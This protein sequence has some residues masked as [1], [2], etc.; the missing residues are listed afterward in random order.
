MLLWIIAIAAA[1]IAIAVALH[2][3]A[4]AREFLRDHRSRSLWSVAQQVSK[5][6][7]WPTHLGVGLVLLA[8]AWWRGK[9]KWMR[10]F[11][12][13]LIALTLAGVAARVV[14]ISVGR[15][16]PSVKSEQVWTGPRLS[17]KFYGFPS[18]HVAASAGFFGVLLFANWRI[19]LS[20][21]AIPLLIGFARMYVGAH[22]LS[23]VIAAAVLGILCAAI[24]AQFFIRNRS[25]E[26]G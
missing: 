17:S 19:G 25:R 16:R 26:P 10:I 22:Y 1:V 7:D 24:V 18:G 23:D 3:D 6:G 9:Q 13:M 14:K 15:A 11:L 2:F 5:F 4:A 21:M 8:V 20:F 12:A